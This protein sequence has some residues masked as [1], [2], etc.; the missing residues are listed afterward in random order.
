MWIRIGVL[1]AAASLAT[2][3]A[4]AG[5]PPKPPANED[6]LACH[7]A[8]ATRDDG[9]SIAVDLKAFEGS[10]HGPMACVD[11]HT[12]VKELPHTDESS[13]VHR[14]QI[15]ATCGSCHVESLQ[16]F[17][18]TFHGQVTSLGFVR[19]ATCADCHGSHD[20]HSRSDARSRVSP[21]RLIETCQRC[22][23]RANA[24]F[25]QY[26]P[27]ADRHSRARSAGLYYAG[28]FM[29]GLLLSVFAF[30]GLHTAAWCGRG[31]IER[32]NARRLRD[33]SAPRER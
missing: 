25:V 8:T 16:T 15:P 11:C 18:D 19:V 5:Q 33:A 32:R 3:A 10:T 12:G 2:T 1:V 29:D 6:C 30:F 31:L 23:Q 9:R 26:D 24:N 21:G 22:H 4:A 7:D 28:R 14:T 27:H 17:R 20:I 13:G